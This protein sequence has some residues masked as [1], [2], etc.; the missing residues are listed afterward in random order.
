M[1]F[2][3]YMEE[4]SGHISKNEKCGIARAI[5]FQL[6]QYTAY[7]IVAYLLKKASLFPQ[8]YFT[9]EKNILIAESQNH[10]CFMSHE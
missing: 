6:Q 10:E 7:L 3:N 1:T 4:N 8:N 2:Y 5:S 9:F